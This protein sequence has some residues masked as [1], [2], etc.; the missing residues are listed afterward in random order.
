MQKR[1]N[2]ILLLFVLLLFSFCSVVTT[3]PVNV[4]ADTGTSS[5]TEVL[6][7]LSTNAN[8][9]IN[10]Y[11]VNHS[12]HSLSLISIAESTNKELFVYV[13]QADSPN[14]DL[15]A[16]SINI[17]TT[18]GDDLNYINYTLSVLDIAGTLCKYKVNNFKVQNTHTRY[19]D[20]TSIYRAWNSLYDDPVDGDNTVAE[21]P[22][23][24]ARLY[25]FETNSDKVTSTCKDIDVIE[26]TDKYCG[27]VR[28]LQDV[29]SVHMFSDV[30]P[31]CDSHFVAFSTDKQIDKLMQA[32][33]YYSTQSSR[34]VRNSTIYGGVTINESTTFGDV[35]PHYTRL[36][37]SDVVEYDVVGRGKAHTYSWNRIQTSQEFLLNENTEYMYAIDSLNIFYS[38]IE[39][40]MTTQGIENISDKQWVLRFTETEYKSYLMGNSGS[41][42][43]LWDQRRIDKTLVGNVSILRLTFET[44][45]V[46]YNMGVIDNKQSGSSEPVNYTTT[47]V[48]VNP[49]YVKYFFAVLALLLLVIVCSLLGPWLPVFFKGVGNLFTAPFKKKKKKDKDNIIVNVNLNSHKKR[50]TRKKGRRK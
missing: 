27:F 37:Y 15:V 12:D 40:K 20:I 2:K 16:T 9:D 3:M 44:D 42:N 39:T 33:V 8:F 24:V 28:Y 45:G 17:S 38:K 14:S 10:N 4:Y 50:R 6:E 46:V 43:L 32:D 25:T 18:I 35:I 26:I 21:V 29:H 31:S 7:D 48:V 41:Y 30:Y 19:Y 34:Y 49:D 11:P 23:K 13:Y 36:S 22:F 5:Y 1:L 47:S